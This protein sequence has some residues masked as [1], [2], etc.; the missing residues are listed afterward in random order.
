MNPS[1]P[2]KLNQPDKTQV[3]GQFLGY[4]LQYT[5][6]ASLL[7]ES[8]GDSFVSLEVFEDVG[9]QDSQQTLASQ[10]KSSLQD[11]PVSNSAEP[12]WK[13]FRNWLTAI[14]NGQLS[15]DNTHFELYVF[16][17]F[18]GDICTLFSSANTDEDAQTAITKARELLLSKSKQPADRVQSVLDDPLL[19]KLLPRFRY[20]HGTG[21]S[22]A[23]LEEQLQKLAIPQEFT[24]KVLLHLLGWV[25][26]EIDTL[27]E[28]HRPAVISVSNF[29][30]ELTS[31][32]RSL[33]FSACLTDM[34]GPALPEDIEKD[35]FRKY[36]RQLDLIDETEE[37]KLR[38][39]SAY[40]RAS[41]NR[42]EWGLLGLVH[43]NGMDDFEERLKTYW[44]NSRTQCEIALSKNTPPE[45]GR[46]LLA[47]CMKCSPSLQGRSVPH[48]FVEGCFH[49]LSEELE[50][51]WHP[52]FESL[53][54]T[55]K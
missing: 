48:D 43:E 10:T 50:I 21:N 47:E 4:G 1:E 53:T 17:D 29:R 33:I 30:L 27:I 9:V 42:T 8:N 2:G 5:R 34:A 24:E 12:F 51:G 31:F 22:I 11:N 55:W 45:R 19:T 32:A 7:L 28:D 15:L 18:E 6:F 49:S 52:Q 36:V 13:T 40:L 41:V 46:Y 37:R 3:P 35:K 20:R 39:I 25:K 44:H 16:G 38:A 54:T 23:D 26:K 14:K